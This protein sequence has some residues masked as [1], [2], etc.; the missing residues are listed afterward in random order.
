VGH[1]FQKIKGA[2]GNQGKKNP[3]DHLGER[4]KKEKMKKFSYLMYHGEYASK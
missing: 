2:Y 3:G 1:T 4:L